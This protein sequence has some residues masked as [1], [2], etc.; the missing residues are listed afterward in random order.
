MNFNVDTK[1][2]MKNAVAWQNKMLAMVKEGGSWV[3]PRSG[4]IYKVIS[5]KAKTVTKVPSVVDQEEIIDRVL[6][7]AGW[8]VTDG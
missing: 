3:V 4:T 7:A 1:D 8:T 5:H 2:G 6:K